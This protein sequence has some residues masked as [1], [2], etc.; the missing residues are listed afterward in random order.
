MIEPKNTFYTKN[1]FL[2]KV[3]YF[4]DKSKI[5]FN[6]SKTMA[7]R[8]SS[9]IRACEIFLD[10]ND[11]LFKV[12]FRKLSLLLYAFQYKYY[13]KANTKDCRKYIAIMS[14]E[15]NRMPYWDIG[16]IVFLEFENED[17]SSKP[18]FKFS[19][20][21]NNGIDGSQRSRV[22][23]PVLNI[24]DTIY[25]V[26]YISP[27]M[28]FDDKVIHPW[29][30]SMTEIGRINNIDILE[31]VIDIGK[32]LGFIQKMPQSRT[33]KR[34][35]KSKQVVIKEFQKL[36]DFFSNPPMFSDMCCKE[37]DRLFIQKFDKSTPSRI[38]SEIEKEF[39]QLPIIGINNYIDKRKKY[40]NKYVKGRANE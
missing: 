15:N 17:G 24:V 22:S 4:H 29:S 1:D 30:F 11:L 21:V 9:Y 12:D 27:I 34:G 35:T 32:I 37:E 19:Y 39:N 36:I 18:Y 26:G 8:Y 25:P 6:H 20:Y 28:T 13:F 16:G 2:S 14:Q 33:L 3:N 10:D 38:L 5:T 40:I 23:H 31:E 7:K